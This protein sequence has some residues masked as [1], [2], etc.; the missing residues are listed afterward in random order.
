M[1]GSPH[2]ARIAIP[3]V[4]RRPPPLSLSLRPLWP[5][6]GMYRN[7]NVRTST[8]HRDVDASSRYFRR[9]RIDGIGGAVAGLV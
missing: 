1:M 4:S 6:R 7:T 9:R 2:G 5:L 8:F 3:I